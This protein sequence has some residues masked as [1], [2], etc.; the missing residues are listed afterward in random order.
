[1]AESPDV[2][3]P[4]TADGQCDGDFCFTQADF[5]WYQGYCSG[6]CAFDADCG[7]GARCSYRDAD[8]NGICMTACADDG[9]CRDGYLCEED[10]RGRGICL[11]GA[12]GDG[13][14][15]DGCEGYWD[16]AGRDR[17]FCIEAWPDGYCSEACGDGE[18]CP[19]GSECV[20]VPD[21]EGDTFWFC[22]AECAS[23]NECR[24]DYDCM[25]IGIDVCLPDDGSG[26]TVSTI[27][28]A[29]EI[30]ADCPGDRLCVDEANSGWYLG[31]CTDLCETDAD[32]GDGAHCGGQ[33]D[34]G[35][36]FCY[37]ACESDGECRYGYACYDLTEDGRS[38]CAPLPVETG[39][40]A[41]GDACVGYFECGGG[42][43]SAC[44]SEHMTGFP[45]GYCSVYCGDGGTTCPDGSVCIESWCWQSC[46]G[47]TECRQD[48]GYVCDA[49]DTCFPDL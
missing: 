18:G 29:C 17:G 6:E 1:M 37:R 2:G 31:Y 40:G 49:D 21:G 12:D 11:P 45:G 23:A 8:G 9:E 10:D 5:G 42:E 25:D 27:G 20:G 38:E 28:G 14:V 15:G 34:D 44:F 26:G 16:C 22:V 13:G 32:C 19:E 48:E 47:D 24:A 41:V 35:V 7:A 46:T 43:F 36:G 39:D 33:G 4:C 30:D 3:S